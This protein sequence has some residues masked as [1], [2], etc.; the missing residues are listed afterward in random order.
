MTRRSRIWTQVTWLL[1]AVA[2]VLLLTGCGERSNLKYPDLPATHPLNY[3][4]IW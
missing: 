4:P 1:P 3:K 2:L